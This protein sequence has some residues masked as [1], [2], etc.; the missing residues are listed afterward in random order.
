MTL[1]IVE[2]NL[3][4]DWFPLTIEAYGK[5]DELLWT[6]TIEKP[7]LD[8]KRMVHV[9]GHGPGGVPRM[10]FRFGNG[11]VHEEFWKPDDSGV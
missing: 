10:V 11:E 8:H 4:E 6:K 3:P 5:N 7:D 1:P 9:P 2:H